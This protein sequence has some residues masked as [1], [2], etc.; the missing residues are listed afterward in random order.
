MKLPKHTPGPWHRNIPPATH[1]PT[2]FAG[3]STHI[4]R[5][6][7]RGLPPWEVEA[8]A[9]LIAAAPELADAGEA[10][11]RALRCLL[12]AH[13]ERRERYQPVLDQLEAAIA[14]TW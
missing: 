14:K 12:D 3:R 5:V 11:V 13:P 8:N 2:I 7:E 4:A 9:N 1:Y 10:A 6:V